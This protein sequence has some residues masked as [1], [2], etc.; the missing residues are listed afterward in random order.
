MSFDPNAEVINRLRIPRTPKGNEVSM[1]KK[2]GI[3]LI[4]LVGLV[5]A[6]CGGGADEAEGTA[7]PAR[8][9]RRGIAYI[10]PKS[11]SELTGK[12]LFLN[13]PG[14]VALQIDLENAPSGKLAVHL[15]ETGDCSAPDGTSAGS[16]WN[17]TGEAHGK[18]ADGAHHL[19]DIGNIVVGEDGKG[20]LTLTTDR[21]SMGTGETNDVIG[22]AV[23]V[24]AKADDF[25]TQPTGAAGSR[26]GCGV[27]EEY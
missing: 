16:H 24:H 4:A 26:I 17:P 18:W 8:K 12:A 3:V 11:E 6:G 10:D 15:H 7:E 2:H 1:T 20:S 5:A 25:S 19:G 23:I 14:Q 27:V 22:K 9:I 13:E 21:W